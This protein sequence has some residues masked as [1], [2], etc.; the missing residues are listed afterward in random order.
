MDNEKQD[1]GFHPTKEQES[2]ILLSEGRHLVLAPPGTGK[3]EMLS[4]RVLHALERGI[5]H[6][7]I[8]CLTFT[9]RAAMEMKERIL[10]FGSHR[11]LPELGNIH[12]FC[13]H[14]FFQKS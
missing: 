10:K 9:V 13:H 4:Y 6:E 12:H 5:P 1:K 7:K 14:F 3:T 11:D 2:I 8:L